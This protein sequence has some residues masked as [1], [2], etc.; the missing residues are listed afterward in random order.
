LILL[1]SSPLNQAP[2][3]LASHPHRCRVT[4]D[5]QIAV[6][7]TCFRDS[8]LI[9]LTTIH[10]ESARPAYKRGGNAYKAH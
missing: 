6:K 1:L 8:N 9:R 3:N 2:G 10:V 4:K 7:K 5:I